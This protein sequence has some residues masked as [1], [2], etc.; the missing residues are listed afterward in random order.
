[1]M[2]RKSFT[3]LCALALATQTSAA[4]AVTNFT[5][6]FSTNASG[7]LTGASTAP[8]YHATGGVAGSG[9][10]SYTST[11]T[12]AASGPMGAPPLQILM[13]GNNSA[14]ASGDAFVGNWL[15][16]GVDSL[17]VAIRHNYTTPLTLYARLNAAAGAAASSAPSPAYTIA[18]NTWTKLTLP[19]INSNPPFLSFGAGTFNSVFSNINDLQI[20]LYVP[21]STTFTNLKFD[22]DNVSLSVPEPASLGLVGIGIGALVS[23][24]PRR[25]SEN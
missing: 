11:F 5:E 3:L 23:L 22:L 25:R 15:A 2:L 17:S 4:F 19:I 1:M 13:R 8:T 16:D 24:R 7:W 9:Y 6:T 10:I 20:G 12:S 14:N 18:P 21:A